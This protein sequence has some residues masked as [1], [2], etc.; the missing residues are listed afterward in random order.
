MTQERSLVERLRTSTTFQRTGHHDVHSSSHPF[1]LK[2]APKE[3]GAPLSIDLLPEGQV[4]KRCSSNAETL[5]LASSCYSSAF[6]G[7][8]WKITSQTSE[9]DVQRR[10]FP[11]SFYS[12]EQTNT[13]SLVTSLVPGRNSGEALTDLSTTSILPTSSGSTWKCL[14]IYHIADLCDALGPS[15]RMVWFML[16]KHP[17]ELLRPLPHFTSSFVTVPLISDQPENKLVLLLST[18]PQTP[19]RKRKLKISCL[20]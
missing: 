6:Y 17:L 16:V 10:S 12:V 9:S 1:H 3:I 11:L 7:A 2:W 20:R 13:F 18:A 4:P 5:I 15:A 19:P 14:S 8:D